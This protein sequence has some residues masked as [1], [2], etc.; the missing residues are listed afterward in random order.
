MPHC[1]VGLK[2]TIT[3]ELYKKRGKERESG[4]RRIGN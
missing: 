2:I 1:T 3:T 4:K